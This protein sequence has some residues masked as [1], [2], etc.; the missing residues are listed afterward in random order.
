MCFYSQ[1]FSCPYFS[2]FLFC[3]WKE[4]YVNNKKSISPPCNFASSFTYNR[5]LRSIAFQG[6]ISHYM[7]G[8]FRVYISYMRLA[9]QNTSDSTCVS[10]EL[11]MADAEEKE[12][13]II[14]VTNEQWLAIDAFFTHYE[15]DLE[16]MTMEQLLT[17]HSA[18]PHGQGETTLPTVPVELRGEEHL[19]NQVAR[20]QVNPPIQVNVPAEPEIPPEDGRDE[21]LYCFCRPCV[22]T[23][24]QGW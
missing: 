20:E 18:Q 19:N 24:R 10:T 14:R 23:Y 5:S 12:T 9:S 15:W 11:M 4:K 16:E 22:T 2:K 1:N 7:A 21:C 6:Y 3:K 17:I 8:K 13:H